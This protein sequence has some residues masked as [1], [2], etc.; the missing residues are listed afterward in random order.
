[1]DNQDKIILKRSELPGVDMSLVDLEMV[2]TVKILISVV[3]KPIFKIKGA[4]F[5]GTKDQLD[6]MD[7]IQ[8]GNLGIKYRVV[9]LQKMTDREGYIYRIRR[10]D[11]SSTTILDIE[12]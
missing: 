2:S 10:M 11:G 8:V 12:I 5:I 7:V 4:T 9:K 3:K 1:V 6:K